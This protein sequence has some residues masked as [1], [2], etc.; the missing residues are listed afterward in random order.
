MPGEVDNAQVIIDNSLVWQTIAVEELK[1][2]TD[3]TRDAVLE[4]RSPERLG[5]IV[6][7]DAV[8]GCL[9]NGRAYCPAHA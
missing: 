2:A 4:Q 5:A 8:A 7:L 3:D 9:F 6:R 1:K